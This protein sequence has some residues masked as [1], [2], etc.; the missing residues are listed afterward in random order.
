MAVLFSPWGN[1]QFSASGTALASGHKIYT[2]AAGSS[3]PLAT[4]TDSTGSTSQSNP[5][6]LNALGLPA[7]GQIWLTAGLAYKLVWTDASDVVIKTEDNITGVTSAASVSQW[8]ASGLTPT[9]VS[10]TSFTLA[11]DQ[12]SAFHVGRRLQSTV[13]AGTVYSTI[14][15]TAYGALTT[16]TVVNDGSGALDSGMS[17]VSYGL[18]TAVDTS[19]PRI[20]PTVQVFTATGTYTKPAGVRKIRV[21]VVGGGGGGGGDSAANVSSGGGGGGGYS[22]KVIDAAAITTVAVTVGAGGVGAVGLAGATGGTSSFGAFCTATGGVG[23][24][25]GSGTGGAS[26]GGSGGIGS[27][28]DINA[29]GS[30][31]SQNFISTCGGMG[32]ASVLGGGG[33]AINN[34]LVAAQPGLAYGGGGAGG[35]NNSVAYA[36]GNGA[37]GVCIVE[38]FY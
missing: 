28:G 19:L 14:S 2:Y 18:I 6:I 11:G 34:T 16:V 22:E 12:T 9:Y 5:I 26:N 17:A 37:P 20:W 25:V 36:G 31:G 30:A 15:T 24:A 29:G 32:G 1:Q 38:E 13:T 23:G 3:T 33:R 4:F 7:N 35:G 10:A 8:Q 27:G 21:R